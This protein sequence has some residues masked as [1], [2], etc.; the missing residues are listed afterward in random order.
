MSTIITKFAV[1]S[2]KMIDELLYLTRTWLAEHPEIKME[3]Q[4]TKKI[5]VNSMNS[6]SS[7]WFIVYAEEEP[8]GFAFLTDGGVRP[9]FL[10]GKRIVHLSAFAIL[11]AHAG[12]T[13]A[14]SLLEKCL[15]VYKGRDA[16]WA[17]LSV[18]PGY[19]EANGFVKTAGYLVKEMQ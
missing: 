12:G 19:L 3:G 9:P 16:M 2:D 5:L 10:E 6:F 17:E 15:A 14:A 18:A 8:A 13:A 1:A 7:Q 11:Q 4:Y